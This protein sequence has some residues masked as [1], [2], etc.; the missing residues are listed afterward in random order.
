M[1]AVAAID[2]DIRRMTR[3]SAACRR[4]MTIPGVGQLTA[5]AFVAAIDDPFAYPPIPRRR[6]LSGI[7]PQTVSVGRGRLRR[8]HL[9]VRGPAGADPAV[10]SRQCHVDPLQRPAQA[11]GLGLRDRQAINDAQGQS[12]SGAPPRDH[13]ACDAARRD[14]VRIGLSRQSTRQ[15]AESSSQEERRPREG[16]D[17][18]ADFVA[19]GQPM[20]DCDFNRAALHPAYPIKCRTS[21]QRT[22]APESVDT[23]KSL[24]PLDPLE[25][26]IR[27]LRPFA[28]N[29]GPKVLWPVLPRLRR[30]RAPS[31]PLHDGR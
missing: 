10:R 16:A 11:Q 3:A 14:R 27:R 4:L 7:G 1:T 28:R 26:A 19:R 24:S 15:E 12:R 8:Q 22:Q 2:A 9:E 20:T 25:N 5:L 17:D 6:R 30:A 13:H 23:P 18:G 29:N 31:T 21:T